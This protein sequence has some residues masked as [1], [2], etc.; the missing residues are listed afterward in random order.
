MCVKN[1]CPKNLCCNKMC[2]VKNVCI[3][4]G[5]DEDGY[6]SELLLWKSPLR[7]ALWL[8]VGCLFFFLSYFAGYSGLTLVR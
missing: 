8:T 1:M 5:L 3:V 4:L 6:L 7:S 2:V